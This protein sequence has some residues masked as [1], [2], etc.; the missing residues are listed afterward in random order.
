MDHPLAENRLGG[1]DFVHVGVE[2]VAA[3]TGEVNDIRFGQRTARGQQ[4]VAGL[5]LFEIFAK[6]VNAI[7]AHL[8]AAYPLLADGRQ[9]RWA[10]LDGGALHIVFHRTQSAEL[11]S[12]A[13]AAGAAMHQL[14][15]R[16]TVAG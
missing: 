8:G 10:A 6:R 13:C 1:G 12:A 4:T 15:Q 9:H 7:F 16:R 5:D 14:R 11:L 2:M 3:Q